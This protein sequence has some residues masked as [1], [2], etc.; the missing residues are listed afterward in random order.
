[1]ANDIYKNMVHGSFICGCQKFV[2]S[3]PGLLSFPFNTLVP[4]KDIGEKEH[5]TVI[6]NTE[7]ILYLESEREKKKKDQQLF[8]N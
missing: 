4:Q 8:M 3:K 2:I 6:F 5:Y 7:I 1:M